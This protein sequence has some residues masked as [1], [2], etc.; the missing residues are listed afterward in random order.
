MSFVPP[1][2]ALPPLLD[3][4]LGQLLHETARK[5]PDQDAVVYVDRDYRLTWRQFDELTDEL[6]KGLMALGIRKGE[7]VAVWATNVPFWVALMFAT[8]KMGAILLTVNTAY[9]RNELKYLMTNSEAENI[10]IINGFRDSDYI[11]ILYALAPE[12]RTME[13]GA[14]TSRTFPF[15]KRVCFLGVEKHRGMYSIPEI[16]GL[17]RTV[18]DEELQARQATFTCHDVVNMQYTSGTTGFPKGVMLSHHNIVNNG[19]SIGQRQ[20]FSGQ[21]KLCIQ[22]PLFH[23]FGCVLAVM[24]CVN[25]GTTMVFT[26]VFNPITSMTSIEQEKCT[27]IYGV[28]TMFIAILEHPLFA[29][30]DF[31]SLRTGIMAGS[32]CPTQTMRQ[33]TEKMYMR[34][35]TSVYGLTESSP[36]MTQ[37]DVTDP[38]HYRVTGV[39]RHSPTSRSSGRSRNGRGG[40]PRHHGRTVLPRLQQ[41]EGLLQESRSHGPMHRRKRLG[42]L[43][44]SRCHGRSTAT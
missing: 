4:T 2:L 36:G 11:E 17:A 32:V 37:T 6:A 26:E 25:H 23:C 3:L 20:R 19:Y 28:P 41:D 8:A 15:L 34:Q 31:S 7:K 35:I 29:K 21:D 9:K 18:S 24:A 1:P 5:Y 10:F 30:F 44:R 27:A 42:S 22:V 43:R 39:G 12:L 16:M 13:R 14:I 38:L 40:A 33:V